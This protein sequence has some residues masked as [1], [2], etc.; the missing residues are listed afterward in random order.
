MAFNKGMESITQAEHISPEK[1]GDTIEAK[2]VALYVFDENLGDNGEWVRMTQP[3]GGS[4]G[5]GAIVDGVSSSIK[6]TV[7]DLTNSNPLATQ[8]VDASGDAITSFGGGVQYTEGTSTDSTPTGTVV[9]YR[10][11]SDNAIIGASDVTP[12]PVVDADGNAILT[13]INTNTDTSATLLGSIDTNTAAI[14]A[15]LTDP[16]TEPTL[17]A[18][19]ADTTTIIGHVNGIE[20]LL[21]TIDTDTG[22]LAGTDFM[23]GTDFSAVFGT[24]PM[25][26][27]VTLAD[28]LVNTTDV[29][30][31]R[32]LGYWFNGTDW[33]RARG[34]LTNGLL[35]NLG[36]NN[37]VV[38]SATNLDIRDLVAASDSVAVH[39]DVGVLDQL[40]LTNSNPAAVA[41][42]DGDGTQI[43]SFGGGTQ[44]TEDA[45]AAANP[46]G[47][48]NILVRDDTPGTLTSDDG[49]NV[50]QRGTNYGAAFVQ[51][52]NS[53]GAFI[54][55]FGG[56]GGTSSA[57]GTAFNN[58]TTDGTPMMGAYQVTPDNLTDGDLGVVGLTISRAMR[59]NVDAS[60]LPS[61]AATSAKQ[62]TIIGHV[63]GIEG[64]LTTIAGDTTDIEAA[65]ETVG[66]L[67]VNLGANNDVTVTGTV[68][69]G[70]TDNAVLD[71]IAASVAAIDTD[72]STIIGHVDG[73]E[74]LLGT[75]DADTSG[76]ITAVQ[77]IDDTIYVDDADFTDGT[78][79]GQGIMGVAEN[80]PTT[81]TDGD[82]GMVGIDPATR[83]MKIHDGGNSITVDNAGLTELAGAINASAQMDVNVAA[84]GIGL[85]T[86]AAHDAAFG[87]AG[88][89][90]A[91]VRTIQGVA[92]MTPVQVSQATA[93]NLNMTEASA[94][95][96]LTALQIM[97]DW[98]NGA[99]DGASVSGDVA[100]DAVDAGEPVKIGAK[101]YSPDG[102]TPG[103]AVAESDRTHLKTD[104]D[105]NLYVRTTPATRG[106]KHL[107]GSSAYTDESIVADPGDGF[108]VVITSIIASTG[109]ATALNFFLE[110]GSTTVFGPIYLEAV[111]GRGFASGPIHLPITAST[112]VTLTSS[113]A[114]AQSFD[115]DYYIQAV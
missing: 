63:D 18:I 77:L 98:D 43:T 91:Q 110:E 90:D 74:A 96:S 15:S 56:S 109:A 78:S 61:G 105:G 108:Q 107:N 24:N 100:H 10:Q 79:L 95:S 68:D 49:D 92:S 60:A 25:F 35:V 41:I 71:A 9:M 75:I 94:A 22:V 34:D 6:A 44:Y 48:A 17:A 50:A 20:G 66:G 82:M 45:A 97:D 86:T 47:T 99:S 115:I 32:A 11:N 72:T 4:G 3:G 76:I 65:L 69:L 89:A 101:A 46:V 19:L 1:T 38:V 13:T 52:V 85:L 54:D 42:V 111:A 59:V 40:D 58:D 37:D 21:T 87:T 67:V 28:G 93:S 113:A 23:L 29:L 2:R 55:T 70:A 16:A 103:T 106:H 102:T 88:S 57:D 27:T 12:L 84:N 53:S 104:L 73:I 36:S 114:I 39:G 81:V 8:I 14:A 51:V 30:N 5:D 64:L 80:T 31:S 83:A 7:F 62:D 26:T 33:D 112:A